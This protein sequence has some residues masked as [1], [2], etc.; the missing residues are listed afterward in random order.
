MISRI[1]FLIQAFLL[2]NQATKPYDYESY[3]TARIASKME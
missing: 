2:N 3:F 1:D